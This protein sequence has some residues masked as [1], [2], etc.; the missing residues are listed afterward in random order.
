MNPFPENWE[1]IEFFESEPLLLD[2]APAAGWFYNRLTFET[3][4]G[5]DA[6]RCE[7][8]PGYRT[9]QFVWSRAGREL[10]SLD[11]RA[12]SGLSIE[13]HGDK[14]ILAAM[15]QEDFLLPL[16]IQLKPTVHVFWGTK[17]FD[18]RN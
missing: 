1:L 10:V 7:I 6:V 14:E 18:G 8:E 4:R 3:V 15:F 5:E 11:M 2:P 16:R 12:I 17:E 13:K 9:L